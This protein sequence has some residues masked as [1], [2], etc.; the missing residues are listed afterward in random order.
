MCMKE[1][2]GRL[3]LY[4]NEDW[5]E[6]Q[7]QSQWNNNAI[8]LEI[9]GEIGTEGAGSFRAVPSLKELNLESNH[10]KTLNELIFC[11]L[12][13]LEKLNLNG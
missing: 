9:S 5:T 7:F 11:N 6:L 3:E 12:K 1:L 13:N 8:N 4:Q 10:L 2:S